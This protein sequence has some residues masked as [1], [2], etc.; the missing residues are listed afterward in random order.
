MTLVEDWIRQRPAHVGVEWD[1]KRID[2]CGCAKCNEASKEARGYNAS[3]GE[4]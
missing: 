3:Q 4:S 1:G 2:G